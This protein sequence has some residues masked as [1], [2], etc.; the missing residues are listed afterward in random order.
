[1]TLHLADIHARQSPLDPRDHWLVETP[2]VPAPSPLAASELHDQTFCREVGQLLRTLR[3]G[4]WHQPLCVEGPPGLLHYRPRSQGTAK[5]TSTDKAITGRLYWTPA[6]FTEQGHLPG[7]CWQ[8]LIDPGWRPDPLLES[9]RHAP[10]KDVRIHTLNPCPK[11]GTCRR[12]HIFASCD[13]FIAL[14]G[15]VI[16]AGTLAATAGGAWIN[17]QQVWRQDFILDDNGPETITLYARTRPR[18]G[19]PEPEPSP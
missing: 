11:D 4:P 18:P 6:V 7:T 17:G 14:V 9:I 10:D 15:T 12:H 1:M 16:D 2:D 3:T 13:C 5:R 19:A 8:Q